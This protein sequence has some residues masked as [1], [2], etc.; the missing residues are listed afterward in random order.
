MRQLKTILASVLL[1]ASSLMAS[2]QNPVADE[3][4][5]TL[6]YKPQPYGFVQLQGGVNT[7]NNFF[8]APGSKFNPTFS[9]AVGYMFSPIV[10]SRLHFNGY[11]TKN[12]FGS[13][14]D[15][16]KHKYLTSDLDLMVNII[17]IFNKKNRHPVDLY[18]IG[19]IGLTY[20]W[21]NAPF[22][23]ITGETEDISNAWGPTKTPR[24]SL[25]S[26]N[27]RVGLLADVNVAKHWSVGLEVD[28]NSLD[29]RFNS[30]Y[31]NIDDWLVT[32]QLSVTYKFGFGKPAKPVEAPVTTNRDYDDASKNANIVSATPKTVTATPIE[33][34]INETL[35]YAIRETDNAANKE[36]VINKVAQWCQKYP[37]KT[38]TVDGY[39]DKGTGNARVN[40]G[41]AQ[42]RAENV[43]KA[44]K[45]KGVPESQ[46]KVASH[47]D[48][49]QPFAEN[50]KNR[51]VII[52]GK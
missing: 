44:L 23:A 21:D 45:A 28:L 12:G 9:A 16:Y 52:V 32:A 47:G 43:A 33:E 49:V 37:N 1:A 5:R 24:Q 42:Q 2:A 35:F 14:D 40:D 34:P 10:G 8:S 6:G 29:D 25:L 48:S 46:I 17:N 22:C 7:V 41:Y 4:S 18:L 26:H 3:E 38:V 20:A 13:I 30:K 36:A 27:L 11:E 50:D 51:C 31:K 15:T 39:A 19:G